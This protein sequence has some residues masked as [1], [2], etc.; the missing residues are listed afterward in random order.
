[1]HVFAGF[2]CLCVVCMH[3]HKIQV[4]LCLCTC[5]CVHAFEGEARLLWRG[6][7]D[8]SMVALCL[9]AQEAKGHETGINYIARERKR[10]VCVCVVEFE[11]FSL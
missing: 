8:T 10:N 6:E 3:V 1:M 9:L 2:M 4:Y 7:A 5:D 11:I